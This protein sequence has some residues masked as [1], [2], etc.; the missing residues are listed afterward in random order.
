MF[1]ELMASGSGGEGLQFTLVETQYT[2]SGYTF[3]FTVIDS[4]DGKYHYF[5]M[6]SGS[7]NEYVF[8]GLKIKGNGSSSFTFTAIDGY[9]LYEFAPNGGM[10]YKTLTDLGV[11]GTKTVSPYYAYYQSFIAIK[12]DVLQEAE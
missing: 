5:K 11:N 8:N 12:G 4:A 7:T 10:G 9:R 6:A 2:V 1:T 3:W